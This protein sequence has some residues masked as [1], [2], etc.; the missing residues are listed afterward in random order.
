M[1]LKTSFLL[2]HL[3]CNV[4]F[5]FS[6]FHNTEQ[7]SEETLILKIEMLL[8]FQ[9]KTNIEIIGFK[10]MHFGFALVSSDIDL[11]NI[12]LLDT[13]L[14]FARRLKDVLENKKLLSWRPV[15]DLFKTCL[16]DV[17]KTSWRPTNGSSGG[18]IVYVYKFGYLFCWMNDKKSLIGL[19][20]Q[21]VITTRIYVLYKIT[22]ALKFMSYINSDLQIPAKKLQT[23]G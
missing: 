23:P 15:E 16:E 11:R 12:D 17:L 14:Y 19:K 6:S 21:P 9:N 4:E 2:P 5:E 13:R 8:E 18:S 7:S 22:I 10:L 3:F 20:V 1:L